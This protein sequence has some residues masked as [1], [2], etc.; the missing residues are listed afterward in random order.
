MEIDDCFYPHLE[1][2]ACF[3][4]PEEAFDDIDVALLVGGMPRKDG[5]ER[6]ELLLLNVGI[7]K[8]QGAALE[9]V[10]KKTCK[11]LVVA[12]PA[13]SNCLALWKHCP[14]IPRENFTAL[15]RLDHN[16][17]LS[18]VKIHENVKCVKDVIIW[19]NHSNTQFPDVRFAKVNGE[20]FKN[21]ED[22]FYKDEFLKTVQTRGAAVIKARGMSSAMSAAKATCDHI[23]DWFAGKDEIV[24]MGVIP[25]V[26]TYGIDTDLCFSLPVRCKGNFEY[27]IVTGLE[28]ND[29]AKEKL[30]I[31]TKELKEEKEM[32]EL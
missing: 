7:F 18:Q 29:F 17:A 24:S 30:A 16:R 31:T 10:A 6:K 4:N 28:L 9:K 25:P 3:S 14:S 27:E 15:T 13:N 21:A 11:I 26:G 5:M 2:Y 23:K 12:N 22:P 32:A 8:T 1:K 20:D 19:G